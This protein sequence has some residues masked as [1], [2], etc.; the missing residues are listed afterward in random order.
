MLALSPTKLEL[1][2][3]YIT[4]EMNEYFTEQMVIDSIKGVRRTSFK[5]NLG[6]AIH[7]ILEK[8]YDKFYNPAT[9]VFTVRIKDSDTPFVFTKEEL[10]TVIAYI[11]KKQ[12]S[13]NE[14]PVHKVVKVGSQQVLLRMKIDEMSGVS[15]TDHKTSERPLKVSYFENSLQWKI[16]VLA[17][18][19]R[20][21][22]YNY[23]QY[24]INQESGKLMS[25]NHTKFSL[26]PY[27]DMESDVKNWIEHFIHFCE[28]NGLIDFITY[29]R[30]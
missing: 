16:Y 15:A 18:Q 24:I 19:A 22:Y 8:G 20:I 27:E 30:K 12:P 29:K 17:T 11:D 9:D 25:I 26:Y 7:L 10:K 6:T 21:F 1:F 4:G 3:K 14:V 13:V 2:R 5:A 23:F 28:L